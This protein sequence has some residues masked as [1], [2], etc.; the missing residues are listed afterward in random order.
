MKKFPLLILLKFY[1]T[2]LKKHFCTGRTKRRNTAGRARV[3]RTELRTPVLYGKNPRQKWP[4]F[5]PSLSSRNSH[6][7][8]QIASSRN[9]KMLFTTLSL[10]AKKSRQIH[11]ILYKKYVIIVK[12][13]TKTDRKCPIEVENAAGRA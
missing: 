5:S 2:I 4:L 7:E 12:K 1:G 13:D 11:L 6:K 3:P 8:G 9:T 10:R